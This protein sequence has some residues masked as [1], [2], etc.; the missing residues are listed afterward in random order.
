MLKFSGQR[1]AAPI[2]FRP[3]GCL[4]EASIRRRLVW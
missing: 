4:V 2:C 3:A 1:E